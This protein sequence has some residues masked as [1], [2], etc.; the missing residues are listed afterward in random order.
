MAQMASHRELAD[1]WLAEDP[2][3][4]TAGEL[5]ALLAACD[6]Q[7]PAALEDLAERFTGALEFGTAGLRGILGAGPQRMNRVLVRKVSAGLAA[8]LLAEVPGARQRGVVI[9]HDARHNSRVF[10]EDTARV[11]GGAG[12]KSYLAHRPW[13]TPTTAWAVTEKHA[14]AGVMVTASHNPP[15]YNGYKVYWGNG[16]QIIPPHDAGIAAQIARIGRSD[17]LAMPGLDELRGNGTLIDLTEALHDDY[18]K[19]VDGLRPNPGAAGRSLVIA[20]T[21]LHGVGALSVEGSLAL[22]GFSRVHTELSQRE[23]DPDFPTVAFPNPE[24]KGAMDRVLAL[25]RAVS[26]E[27]VLANDPDADRLCVAVPEG[28]GGAGG[29]GAGYRLLTGDQAG[30]L[31]ADYL[32]ETGARDR[33]M[34]ATTIVSSQLLGFL[35]AQAG[36]D[37]R[38]T[39]TGFKWIGNAA[40]EYERIHGGRFVLGYE[41]ALGYSVGPLVRDKDGVSA[42]LVFAE[43]TAWDRARGKSVLEH[44]DDIYRKVGLFV[45][46]QVSLTRPG[47]EGLAQIRDAM[48][49]FRSAPPRE[50]AGHAIDQVVDLSRGEGGLP[51][52]DVLVFKLAGGRRVIMRPSGT[53]PKLKSYYEVRVE[54]R[55]GEPMTEARARGLAELASLRDAHQQLLV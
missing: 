55:A 2:D 38:E 14:C 24:E 54:V 16:A 33:R 13:P 5:R 4:I 29:A 30:A 41:E 51:P 49:R 26:A 43:L 27:L 34:V 42:A 11:L 7:D 36:A 45:T 17:Q 18:L 23:P 46:E 31:L 3:P 48:T 37:Y 6:A 40:M 35:A 19:E 50:L 12:I 20:Y 52:A 10:A 47:A 21:P 22:A 44:L 25:A 28:A 53:E 1:A 39:L 8:Y 9:G 15:A 32:L